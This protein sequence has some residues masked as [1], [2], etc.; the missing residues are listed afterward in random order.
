MNWRLGAVN[1]RAKAGWSNQSNFFLI[2]AR[3]LSPQSQLPELLPLSSPLFHL[4]CFTLSLCL[5]FS[6][7]L[8]LHHHAEA[9]SSSHYSLTSTALP[10]TIRG[11]PK[12]SSQLPCFPLSSVSISFPCYGPSLCSPTVE[13]QP[14]E[15]PVGSRT[16]PNALPPSTFSSS[17]ACS[18]SDWQQNKAVWWCVQPVSLPLRSLPATIL[19]QPPCHLPC[20]SSRPS[21]SS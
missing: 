9:P 5:S 15:P 14:T 1:G 18:C 7:L 8:A 6:A 20:P 10:P 2:P 17:S 13:P 16:S 11:D 21:E 19:S 3:L 4:L 12:L